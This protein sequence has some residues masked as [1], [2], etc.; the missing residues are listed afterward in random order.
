LHGILRPKIY[1]ATQ[2]STQP[3]TIVLICNEPRAFTPSYRRYLLGILRDNLDFGEVPI[4]MYLHKR[5]S[6]DQRDET[7]AGDDTAEEAAV[8]EKEF[9]EN[10]AE[11]G[12]ELAYDENE[13]EN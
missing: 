6:E 9:G 10:V 13:D 3:P 5:R 1:Y 4:K 12:A 11:E 2:V 7:G 8:I